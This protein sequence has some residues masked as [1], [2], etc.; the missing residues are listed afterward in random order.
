MSS[1]GIPDQ[2]ISINRIKC[3]KYDTEIVLLDIWI[4]V[5]VTMW[6]KIVGRFLFQ[7]G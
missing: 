2:G 7:D 1:N 4:L 5:V 6:A 3:L